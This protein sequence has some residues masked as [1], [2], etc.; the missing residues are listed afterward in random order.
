LSRL[1]RPASPLPPSLAER[2]ATLAESSP[3]Q[4]EAIAVAEGEEQLRAAAIERL[5]DG[6]ALRELA[7]LTRDRATSPE[8]EMVAQQRL[9]TLIDRQ[10]DMW[11]SLGAAAQ[12]QSALLT[13]A[14]LCANPAPLEGMVSAIHDPREILRLVAEGSSHRLRQLA[15]QR[16]EDREELNRLLKQLQGKDKSVYRILKEKRDALR[17]EAQQ[18]AHVEQ[19]IR[20][21][22][23]SL[24]ALLSR[25]YDALFAP[26]VEHFEARWQTFEGQAQPWA[27]ERVSTAIRRCRETMAAHLLEIEQQAARLAERSARDAALQTAREEATTRAAQLSQELEESATRDAAAAEELRHAEQIARLEREAADAQQLRQI[28]ALISRAYGALRAGHT[29]PAAGLRRALEEKLTAAPPLPPSLARGLQE[30]DAKLDALKEWKDYAVS[31]K[32]AELIT[33]MEALIGSDESPTKLADRIRDL[34][35][36]WKTISQGVMVDSESDWQQFNQAAASAYEPCRVY[37]EEQS[38]LRA[39]NVEKRRC[40]LERLLAFESKQSGEHPDWRSI[41]TVLYEAPQ[42]WRGTGPVDRRAVREMEGEFDASLGRLRGRLEAWQAQNAETKRTFIEQ[43]KALLERPNSLEGVEGIKALQHRWRDIGP[44]S[45]EFEGPLWNEFRE[46]CDAVFKKREQANA[47]HAASLEG[48]KIQALS[49]CEEIEQLCA[50]SGDS[51]LEGA[52]SLSQRRAAFENVGEL[53]RPDARALQERFSRAVSQCEHKVR[54]QRVQDAARVFEDLIEATQ[55]IQAYGWAIANSAPAIERDALKSE[56]E[57]FIAGVSQWP[58]GGAA[59]LKDVWAKAESAGNEDP[60]ANET[61]LRMLCIRAEIGSERPTP[62]ED[63]TLRR[64]YQLQRL[65]QVM[66]QRQEPAGLDWEALALEWVC[67]GP[68]AP[69]TRVMLLARFRQC[70]AGTHSSTQHK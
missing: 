3:E 24:E 55:R 65:V 10:P 43:A 56:A 30:L 48:H 62:P 31:P 13:I 51:L 41:G 18:A 6:T 34:R 38:R 23:T 57:S 8:F 50:Q 66:G 28:S 53:P 16:V 60:G 46:Q 42:A 63:Q 20:T 64:T 35:A 40:V 7:G 36:Q 52:K 67:I 21:I 45:R 19:D 39:E 44:A 12:N 15:A 9:A 61:A 70:R 11:P 2:I 37:F 54:A 59:T 27:R 4:L 69:A 49:L 25:P 22:Y 47:E 5:P 33:E 26:A 1:F 68:I 32:R 17:A 29:G 58:K 14:E